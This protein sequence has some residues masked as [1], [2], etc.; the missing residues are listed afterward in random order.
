MGI[1]VPTMGTHSSAG[2]VGPISVADALFTKTQQR[3]LAV[4]FG[5]TARSYYANEIIDRAR[6]GSGAV[7]R[8]LAS[9][10]A[11]GLVTVERIGNQ[12]HYRANEK[13]PVFEPLRELVEKTSGL[14]DVLRSALAPL[15]PQLVAAFVF[16]SVARR[17]DR[18]TS[19]VDLLVVSDSLTFADLFGALDASTRTLGREVN[20]QV[21]SRLELTR[22]LKKKNSFVQR[23]LEQPKIWIYGDANVLSTR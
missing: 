18:A 20:P 10:E 14:A 16:G 12:K 13:S 9:L 23:V 19:D 21:Y 3:V 7:Q 1:I 15:A 17:E 22:L 11:S 2:A 4:L 5:D 8:E 6:I